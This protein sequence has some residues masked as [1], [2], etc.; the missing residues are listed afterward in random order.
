M[1]T[2]HR[3]VQEISPQKLF[4]VLQKEYLICKLR[5]FIY[6]IQKH[7]LFWD[8]LS[9]QKKEKIFDL[10]KKYN[11][12]SIFDD[13]HILNE[14]HKKVFPEFGLP[15]FYY[16]NEKVL[17]QQKFWDVKNFFKES[18]QVEFIDI[19]DDFKVKSGKIL[20][21]DVDSSL[22][23]ISS[24]NKKYEVSYDHVKRKLD[25]RFI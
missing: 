1:T 13:S 9:I 5:S 12:F 24:S 18:E 6:P 20:K 4:E 25:F 23:L 19:D 21:V 15:L 3:S 16:P 14:F 10:K 2:N 8:R 11:W 17:F 7:S 22:V